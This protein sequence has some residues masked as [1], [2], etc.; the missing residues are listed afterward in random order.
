M[1]RSADPLI[2]FLQFSYVLLLFACFIIH[3]IC[4]TLRKAWLFISHNVRDFGAYRIVQ[5]RWEFIPRCQSIMPLCVHQRTV[6]L[7]LLHKDYYGPPLSR[8]LRDL[9]RAKKT[10][11]YATNVYRSTLLEQRRGNHSSHSSYLAAETARSSCYWRYVYGS[12]WLIVC[13]KDSIQFNKH[14]AIPTISP[15]VAGGSGLPEVRACPI[16]IIAASANVAGVFLEGI[17]MD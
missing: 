17:M 4:L 12:A 14:F 9:P 13:T 7:Y 3:R 2:F 6:S 11:L 1:Y 5:Q 15:P 10:H 8:P 16:L